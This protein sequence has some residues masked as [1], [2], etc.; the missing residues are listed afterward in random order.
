MTFT[1]LNKN[2]QSSILFLGIF[3]TFLNLSFFHSH[4]INIELNSPLAYGT[5]QQYIIDP[6]LDSSFNCTIQTFSNSIIVLHS[7]E[8]S[9]TN[10]IITDETPSY[11]NFFI[12][13]HLL[14][15]SQLRASPL[16]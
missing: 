7:F 10:L 5:E 15:C 2:R 13:N 12:S 14:H 8:L 6:F 4:K 3:L 9:N 11:Y 1:L 16:S